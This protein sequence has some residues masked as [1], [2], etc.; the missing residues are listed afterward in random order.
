M[1]QEA[2]QPWEDEQEWRNANVAAAGPAGHGK[3]AGPGWQ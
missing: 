3:E 1:L 2:E